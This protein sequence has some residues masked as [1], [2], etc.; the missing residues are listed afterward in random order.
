MA[1]T[2]QHSSVKPQYRTEQLAKQFSGRTR[3][4]LC[5]ELAR[6]YASA[7]QTNRLLGELRDVLVKAGRNPDRDGLMAELRAAVSP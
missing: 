2:Q 3:E 7:E 5:R 4:S 6:M 1:S